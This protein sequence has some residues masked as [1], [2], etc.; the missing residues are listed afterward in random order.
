ML[1]GAAIKYGHRRCPKGVVPEA[2]DW[3]DLAEDLLQR[4][5][6]LIK[7]DISD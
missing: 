4:F 7:R 5:L 2:D 6:G 1:A 3:A